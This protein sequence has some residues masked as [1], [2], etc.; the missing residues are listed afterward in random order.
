MKG[1]VEIEWKGNWEEGRMEDGWKSVMDGRRR[2][3][4]DGRKGQEVR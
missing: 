4:G 3:M 2:W 1:T